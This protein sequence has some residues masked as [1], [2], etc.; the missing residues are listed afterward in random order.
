MFFYIACDN[1][2]YGY[3]C[4]EKCGYC[5]NVT[6]C[7]NING[8]CSTGCDPGN[9]EDLCKSRKLMDWSH[10]NEYIKKKNKQTNNET[11]QNIFLKLINKGY[12]ILFL[13]HLACSYG[14]YGKG[15]VKAC[16]RTCVGCNNI[17]GV[18]G[19][20]CL[21]MCNGDNQIQGLRLLQDAVL[22]YV[23]CFQNVFHLRYHK[24]LK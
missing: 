17:K 20:Q 8:T 5:R 7:N 10:N 1:G 4:S 23:I 14:F 16:T 12:M 13:T 3:E 18:C 11:N 19:K 15:Y 24:K 6:H 21:P 9:I 22:S 2:T